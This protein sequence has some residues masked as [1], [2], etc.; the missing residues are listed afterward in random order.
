MHDCKVLMHGKNAEDLM[1]IFLPIW[2]RLIFA[3]D[4]AKQDTGYVLFRNQCLSCW[5]RITCHMIHHLKYTLIS[6][7]ACLCFIKTSLMTN[8]FQYCLSEKILDGLAAVMFLFKG[9]FRLLQGCTE[10]S[11]ELL[12][13]HQ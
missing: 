10:S 2:R 8:C 11:Y 9:R 6:G 13:K 12:Q 7:T 3:G 5:R 4:S 1:R